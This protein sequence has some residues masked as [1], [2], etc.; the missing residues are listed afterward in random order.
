MKASKRL[1]GFALFNPLVFIVDDFDQHLRHLRGLYGN[2]LRQL[3][4]HSA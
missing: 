3:L 4:G 2:M 1:L